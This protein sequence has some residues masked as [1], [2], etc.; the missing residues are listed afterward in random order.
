VADSPRIQELRRRIQQDPASP[1][2]APLAEELRRAGRLQEAV[3]T[4]RSGLAIHPDYASAR[5]TLGRA[6]LDLGDLDAALTELTRVLATAPEH[7][8][9]L[10]GL[11][12]IHSRRGQR[13][14]ALAAYR[15]A[16]VLAR[17]DA[18]LARAIVTLESEVTG[19]PPATP[20]S[21]RVD[22]RRED[23]VRRLEGFL[24]CILADRARRH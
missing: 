2:F 3:K 12:E 14:E 4:C 8:A 7:L 19:D 21:P 10:K 20:A 24:A 18:E 5:A 23:T 17:D 13:D 1:A 15:R 6:L 22:V 11:G 16:R 9:A